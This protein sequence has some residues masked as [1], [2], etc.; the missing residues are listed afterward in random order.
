VIR[1]DAGEMPPLTGLRFGQRIASP[2]GL[3]PNVE[4]TSLYKQPVLLPTQKYRAYH[5][6]GPNK[7]QVHQSHRLKS[8]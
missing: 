2:F 1:K 5:A 3:S 7:K 8:E 4:A 6:L